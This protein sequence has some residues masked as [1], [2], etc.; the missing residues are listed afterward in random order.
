MKRNYDLLREILIKIEK[1][2]SRF[3]ETEFKDSE[4]FTKEEIIYHYGLLKQAGFIEG[5]L[6]EDIPFFANLTWEGH[7]FLEAAKNSHRNPIQI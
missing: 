1:Q 2:E 7:N 6:Y 5:T 4:D 3:T